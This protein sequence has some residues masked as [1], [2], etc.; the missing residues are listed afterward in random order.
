MYIVHIIKYEVHHYCVIISI[1]L[2]M[3]AKNGY[4]KNLLFSSYHLQIFLSF[5]LF[6]NLHLIHC[7]PEVGLHTLHIL[8]SVLFTNLHSSQ[9]NGLQNFTK[10]KKTIFLNFIENILFFT[11]VRKQTFQNPP[12]ISNGPPLMSVCVETFFQE[13]LDHV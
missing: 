4:H 11:P 9:E 10:E 3:L 1:L 13:P 12:R 5:L 6:Y 7:L 2:I 8:I